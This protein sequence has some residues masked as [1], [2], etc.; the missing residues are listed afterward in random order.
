VHLEDWPDAAL[1]PADD[2][3]VA[4]M[5]QVR[6]VCSTG[7]SLRKAQG[8]RVRLPLATLTVVTPDPAGLEPFTSIV[9]DE[10]NVK[11]VTMLDV[12]EAHESDFG[13]SSRLVVHARAAGPRLGRDVQAAIKGSKSGDWSVAEDGTVVSAGLPLVEGEYT[14]ETVV[15]EEQAGSHATA[16]LPGGGFLVLDTDVSPELELEGAARDIV[17]AV[18][19]A[20]RQAALE[21][22]DRISL[23]ITG[24]DLVHR[25]VQAHRDLVTRETLAVTLSVAPELDALEP[26]D[27]GVSEVVVGEGHRARLRVTKH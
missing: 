17:R 2:A 19:Q 10:L 18:Q 16:M 8:L 6:A 9:A 15:D 7:S 26:S 24:A 23:E 12:R 22:S 1:L 3:L 14:L 20:R 4:A 13:I 27:D 25:A 21:V 5:D 11:T